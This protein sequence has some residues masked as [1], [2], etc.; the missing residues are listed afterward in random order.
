M[1]HSWIVCLALA[2]ACGGGAPSTPTAPAP[3]IT[4]I[5][6]TGSDLLLVGNSE[7]FTAANDTAALTAPRW[8]SDA[9]TVATVDVL[10][11]LVTAVGTGTATIF[12]DESGIR[13]TKLIRTLPD[14]GGSWRGQIRQTGCPSSGDF[15]G[16]L[17][18]DVDLALD[19]GNGGPFLTL[20][21]N[22]DRISGSY[23]F[24]P[25]DVSGSVSPQGTLSFSGSQTRTLFYKNQLHDVRAELQNVRFES[26]Q[27][28]HMTGTFEQ[29]WSSVTGSLRGTV[30][31]SYELV[32][33]TR[34]R[35]QSP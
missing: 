2:G 19:F 4:S 10:T 28:G 12:V 27:S 22:R 18:D 31:I 1:R 20:T 33:M 29:V 34:V 8:G 35:G 6:I 30:R 16:L 3:R 24:A 13:G 9:P 14:F 5:A 32:G 21:Q 23:A 7:K 17:C 15:V 26:T 25:F 11:G